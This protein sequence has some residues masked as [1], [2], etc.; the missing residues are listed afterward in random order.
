VQISVTTRVSILTAIAA[1]AAGCSPPPA[2]APGSG[3]SP[4]AGTQASSASLGDTLR[5]PLGRS[6]STDNGRLVLRFVSRGTDSR[7]P[8][9]VVCVW[10]GDAPVRI[11]ARAGNTSTERELHTGLEPRS[12]TLGGYL[13]SVVGLLPYPGTT[14]TESVPVVLLMVERQ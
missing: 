12:L 8:A 1:F 6:A 14:A 7:C 9:N 2:G 4:D 5:I 11:A 10:M 3:A 13:V